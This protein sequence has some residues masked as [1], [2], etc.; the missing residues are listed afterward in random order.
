MHTV[1]LSIRGWDGSRI[2]GAYESIQLAESAAITYS[3][4]NPIMNQRVQEEFIFDLVENNKASKCIEINAGPE[5]RFIE[6]KDLKVP[7]VVRKHIY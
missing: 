3:I 2:L 4:Q 5:N 7:R 1:I 6:S